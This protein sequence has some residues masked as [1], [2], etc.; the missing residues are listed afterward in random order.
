MGRLKS[1]AGARYFLA[2]RVHLVRRM[3]SCRCKLQ[4]NSQPTPLVE[5]AGL[6]LLLDHAQERGQAKEAAEKPADL[7][8]ILDE[9]HEVIGLFFGGSAGHSTRQ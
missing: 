1:V 2:A 4:A 5:V 3:P 9:L 6:P 7:R 8:S